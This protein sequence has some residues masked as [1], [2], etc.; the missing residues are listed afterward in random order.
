M[1]RLGLY[2]DATI[3]ITGDHT[4]IG[5][6]TK[7]P[8]YAHLTA[9]MVKPRGVGDGELEISTAPVM[10]EDLHATV[11][12]SE[13]IDADLGYGRSIFDIAEDEGRERR[14][15]FQRMILEDG[16]IELVN[17]KIV[18]SAAEF[19]NWTVAE[20]IKLDHGLYN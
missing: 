14:Y 11:F 19:K 3:I 9:L 16:T 17:Y 8:Y 2:E 7:D 6:D 18:G 20:R 12:A 5:S 13:G 15:Y 1:K 4:S 10:Q